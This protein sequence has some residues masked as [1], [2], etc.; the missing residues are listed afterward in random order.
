MRELKTIDYRG[1]IAKFR[2]PSAWVEEYEPSGGGTFYENG[3]D[4]GTLRISVLGFDKP[5]DGKEARSAQEVLA[6][7]D[8]AKAVEQLPS[9]IAISRSSRTTSEAG[10]KLL[11]YNWQIGVPVPPTYFRFVIFTYTILAGQEQIPAIRQEIEL[12]DK[13]IAEGEYPAICG[14]AGDYAHRA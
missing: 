3:P 13:L 7:L 6:S 8:S 4:T 10:E 9:G 5:A 1:G 11:I 2:V 14:E 12:I